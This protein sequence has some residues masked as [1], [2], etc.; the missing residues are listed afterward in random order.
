MEP[1]LQVR[2]K[3]QRSDYEY[4][5]QGVRR[6]KDRLHTQHDNPPSVRGPLLEHDDSI[7]E[8]EFRKHL[9]KWYWSAVLSKDYSGS[10]DTV[11]A[12]DFRDWKAWMENGD[13]IDRI[14]D[15]N[16]NYIQEIDFDEVEKGSARYKAIL[17]MLALNGAK[18]F[19]KG[20][21]V[22]SGD[23]SNDRI[24]DHH[25]FPKKVEGLAP[26]N[27]QS[28]GEARDSILNRTLLL[29][30]TNNKI[31][32]NRPSKYVKDIV[33]EVY[34]GDTEEFRNLSKDHLVTEK[35]IDYLLK[36]NF[37]GFIK[38]REK[39]IKRHLVSILES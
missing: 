36:D 22:G 2:R 28:F 39:A 29:D 30:E 19:R 15:I 24:N 12:K 14:G 26:E 7:Y 21:I 5:K 4:G 37:D 32:N 13:E 18:D 34:G 20:N 33:R 6:N 16:E 27:S 9:E 17:C 10:S 35:G 8:A 25:I 3:S 11:M 31:K 1:L 23:F 38:E